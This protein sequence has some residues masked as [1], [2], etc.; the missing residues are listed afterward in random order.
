MA[1]MEEKRRIGKMGRG[2]RRMTNSSFS[3]I[4]F[5]SETAI[6]FK[7]LAKK[8]NKTHTETLNYFLNNINFHAMLAAQADWFK[9]ESA[10]YLRT[11]KK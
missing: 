3:S 6:K 5:D 11:D 4:S 10:D 7:R 9:G 8:I 2:R 1:N